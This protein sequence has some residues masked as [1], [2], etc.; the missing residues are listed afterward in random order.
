M[1]YCHLREADWQVSAG[2]RGVLCQLLEADC[3]CLMGCTLS[4]T[5]GRLAVS[6][7]GRDVLC[8]LHEAG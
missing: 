8:H 5:C 1:V 3:G 4:F 2:D 7:W 6:A